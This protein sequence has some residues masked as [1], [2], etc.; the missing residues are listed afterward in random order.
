MRNAHV[1]YMCYP[2]VVEVGKE[3][4][5]WI[6]PRDISPPRRSDI[7]CGRK[8]RSAVSEKSAEILKK[9]LTFG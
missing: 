9:G 8:I 7:I 5:V 3:T 4:I 1:R 2:S 6:H